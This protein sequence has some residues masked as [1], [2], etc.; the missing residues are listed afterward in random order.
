MSELLT[1]QN[2]EKLDD[3]QYEKYLQ[4]MSKIGV[5]GFAAFDSVALLSQEIIKRPITEEIGKIA[6]AT[7]VLAFA[8]LALLKVKDSVKSFREHKKNKDLETFE[9]Q[10]S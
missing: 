4:Q 10:E 8:P 6:L 3:M 5:V 1:D 2:V 9:P 7:T